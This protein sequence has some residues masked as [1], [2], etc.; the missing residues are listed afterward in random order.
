MLDGPA[1]PSRLTAMRQADVETQG[2]YAAAVARGT[3]ARQQ[4]FTSGEL[5]PARALADCWG[6]SVRELGAAV[7]RGEVLALVRVRRRYHPSEF[8]GLGRPAVVDI[9]RALSSLPP[10]TQLIFWKRRHGA[11]GGRT[12][13][14]F[15]GRS[16]SSEAHVRRVVDLAQAWAA[17]SAGQ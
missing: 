2:G 5:V 12:P 8:L 1:P 16:G 9:C 7:K 10:E 14:D 13:A 6:M 11:L 4:W 3:A 17:E 15:L